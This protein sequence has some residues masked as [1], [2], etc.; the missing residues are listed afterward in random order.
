MH[1]GPAARGSFDRF[2]GIAE[3]LQVRVLVCI[4]LMLARD[5]LKPPG[6]P[7]AHT[8]PVCRTLC[9]EDGPSLLAEVQAGDRRGPGPRLHAGGPL[10]NDTFWLCRKHS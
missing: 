9:P 8:R 3:K 4:F 1:S 10:V 2:P 6:G 7:V 5:H